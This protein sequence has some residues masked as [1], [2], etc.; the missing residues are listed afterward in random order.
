MKLQTS[1]EWWLPYGC[2]VVYSGKPMTKWQWIRGTWRAYMACWS[3]MFYT[4]RHLAG[5]PGYRLIQT[6][7]IFK[8]LIQVIRERK[9]K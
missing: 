9:E 6:M 8:E 7:S 5:N 3:L 2:R 1:I 4:A